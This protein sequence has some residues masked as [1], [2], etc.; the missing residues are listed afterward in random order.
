MPSAP[1]CL[2]GFNGLGILHIVCMCVA[3][4]AHVAIVRSL[5]TGPHDHHK[6]FRYMYYIAPQM[7]TPQCCAINM[8]L[9]W[10]KKHAHWCGDAYWVIHPSLSPHGTTGS[11]NHDAP[12]LHN[13]QQ[14]ARPQGHVCH[15]PSCHETQLVVCV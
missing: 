3:R 11:W 14:H 13:V 9:W 1:F 4:A 8:T 12:L 10:L 7:P 15:L 6:T 5:S 2:Q